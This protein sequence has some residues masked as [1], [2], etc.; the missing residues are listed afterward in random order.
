M[1]EDVQLKNKINR[2][3]LIYI[4]NYIIF[5]KNKKNPPKSKPHG[6]PLLHR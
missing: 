3:N 2:E 5:I 1:E 4:K 6:R